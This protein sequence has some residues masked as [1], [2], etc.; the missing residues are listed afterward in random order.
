LSQASLKEAQ[1]QGVTE[2]A[3]NQLKIV[4]KDRLPMQFHSRFI[5]I[6]PKGKKRYV[7]TSDSK[8]GN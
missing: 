6:V 8:R 7:K 2:E 4:F 1:N 3:N 5:G